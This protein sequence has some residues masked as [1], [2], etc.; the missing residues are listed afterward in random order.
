[1]FCSVII[2]RNDTAK[3]YE[4]PFYSV[5]ITHDDTANPSQI[6]FYSVIIKFDSTANPSLNSSLS[7]QITYNINKENN[8]VHLQNRDLEG[9]QQMVFGQG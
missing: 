4:I 8:N 2:T 5:I 1:M 3:P 9:K 7:K 6:S